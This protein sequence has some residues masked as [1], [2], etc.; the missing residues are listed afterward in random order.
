M[1]EPV[2]LAPLVIVIHDAPLTAVQAHPA[3]VVT[4]R[5]RIATPDVTVRLVVESTAAHVGADCV[6]E[7]TLPPIVSVPVRDVFEVLAA[8]E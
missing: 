4:C 1:P 5:L 2:P 7:K 3:A 6:T 8:I